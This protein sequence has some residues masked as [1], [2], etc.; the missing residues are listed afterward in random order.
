MF[1]LFS[2][3]LPRCTLFC[4]LDLSLPAC[5]LSQAIKINHVLIKNKFQNPKSVHS[6]YAKEATKDNKTHKSTF[7]MSSANELWKI[8]EHLTLVIT[9]ELATWIS[10]AS[11]PEQIP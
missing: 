1:Y 11:R 8:Y 2:Y 9:N 3:G 7:K 6:E 5:I 4:N 10:S